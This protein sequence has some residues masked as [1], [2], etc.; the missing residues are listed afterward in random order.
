MKRAEQQIHV[1]VV[2][3]L[4]MRGKRGLLFWHTPQGAHYSSRV[5]GK[6]MHGLGVLAGVSDLLLMRAGRF[7][8]LELKAPKGKPTDAQLA[9]LKAFWENGGHAEY[10][11]SLDG[12]IA[13][14]ETWG[15][16]R[17]KIQ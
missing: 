3:H 1:A 15:L 16:L 7:Y 11:D 6:I 5:Q 14:L 9:F 17:G 4:R 2:E 13:T 8:A 10:A 12:A